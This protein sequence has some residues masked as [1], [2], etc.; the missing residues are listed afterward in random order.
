MIALADRIDLE[1]QMGLQL[2]AKGSRTRIN[3]GAK[4]DLRVG[5]VRESY[6]FDVVDIDRYDLILGTPFFSRHKV[7]LNFDE[8]TISIDGTLVPAYTAEEEAEL[9]RLRA[10]QHKKRVVKRL[11]SAFVEDK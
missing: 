4:V 7:V 3:H 10:E 9:L 11:H 6:Y 5:P 8:R 1:E 2:G